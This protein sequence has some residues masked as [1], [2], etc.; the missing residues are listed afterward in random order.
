MSTNLLANKLKRNLN[1]TKSSQCNDYNAP[2][3]I[4]C[5]GN[6]RGGWKNVTVV[7]SLVA[8]PEKTSSIPNIYMEDN[9][10]L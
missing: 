4:L 1:P 3:H 2:Q 7:K 8:L 10:Y 5:N 9:N 6:K